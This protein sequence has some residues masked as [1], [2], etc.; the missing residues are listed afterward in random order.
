MTYTLDTIGELL[1]DTTKTSIR[2]AI[3]EQGLPAVKIGKT[4]LFDADAVRRWLQR[5]TVP[6]QTAKPKRAR[7]IADDPSNYRDEIGD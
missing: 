4:W 2:K 5:D 7:V 1:P 3:R 6:A